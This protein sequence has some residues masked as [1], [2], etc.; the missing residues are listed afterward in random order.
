LEESQVVE[1]EVMQVKVGVQD[2]EIAIEDVST[3]GWNGAVPL[4]LFL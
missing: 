4:V 1:M 2:H 3:R